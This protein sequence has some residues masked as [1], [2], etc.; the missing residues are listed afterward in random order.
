M[1]PQSINMKII[2]CIIGKS[3]LLLYMFNHILILCHFVILIHKTSLNNLDG[4]DKM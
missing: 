4:G 2:V 3:C 1:S